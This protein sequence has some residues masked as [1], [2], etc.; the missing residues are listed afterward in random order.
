[1]TFSAVVLIA[2]LSAPI[3]GA[4]EISTEQEITADE[5]AAREHFVVALRL[6]EQGHIQ[7]ALDTALE[8][9][10]LDDG[11]ADG[12]NL[13]G[14]LYEQLDRDAEAEDAYM[15]A[16]AAD[17]DWAL[18]YRNLGAYYS[19]Q[20][21]FS[22]ALAPLSRAADLWP[23]DPLTHALLANSLQATS[24]LSEAIEAFRRA[25][26]LDPESTELAIDI[27]RTQ[28]AAGDRAAAIAT[29]EVAAERAPEDPR[30]LTLLAQLLARGDLVDELVRAP[31][32]Y[33]QAIALDPKHAELWLGLA[34]A[35]NQI[36]LR[37]QAE[38]AYRRAIELGLDTAEVRYELGQTLSQQQRF[39]PAL[40]Q[41]GRAI[42][43]RPEFAAAYEARGKALFE[44][45]RTSEALADFERAVELS[46]GDP[47]PVLAAVQVYMVQG[48]LESSERLLSG[49]VATASS[50]RAEIAVA[51]GRLRLRQD[52]SAE[53]VEVLAPVLSE[54]PAL[55]EARYLTGQALLKL[56][57][58][59]EGRTMLSEYQRRFN[60]MRTREVDRLRIGVMG[61]AQIYV[62]RGRVF[63]HEERYDLALEQL[64]SAAELAPDNAEVWRALAELH[65]LRGDPEAAAAAL[66]RARA[67]A[68]TDT[69]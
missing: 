61:R 23:D 58:I 51:I 28:S 32:I 63:T 39:A 55:I 37:P 2:A 17:P 30:P 9:L 69:Q 3:L 24:R 57:R 45:N 46:P 38:E 60:E 20:D 42:S 43:D 29:A 14:Q 21:Q 22:L 33:R 68:E 52:R 41:F 7:D 50:Q 27:A 48:D 47:A 34:S 26:E 49:I 56:G 18:P 16:T 66:E 62:L 53:V 5:Q 4:P 19:A 25:W 65:D 40:D 59:E 54:A 64:E 67:L 31:A 36:A 12:L 44:L 13:L 8:A 11:N 1:M 10:A 15:R 35:Y 6:A